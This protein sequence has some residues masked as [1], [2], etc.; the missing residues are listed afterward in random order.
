[1]R[2][3]RH[4]LLLAAFLALRVAHLQADFDALVMWQYE[5]WPM[6]VLAHQLVTGPVIP[7]LDYAD[8][9]SGGQLLTALLAA[10]AF[11]LAGPSDLALKCAGILLA[12][13]AFSV[14]ARLLERVFGPRAA[15]LG[16]A[17][18]VL[19]PPT[20]LRL[21]LT[22]MGNHAAVVPF[23]LLTLLAAHR[24]LRSGTRG[25]A[26][27]FG[28]AA[29]FATYHTLSSALVVL[30]L[31]P[32]IVDL[33]RRRRGPA[34][35]A[36]LACGALPL[37]V[38]NLWHG[39]GLAAFLSARF[40][41]AA[42]T[43]PVARV[44]ELVTRL[45][46]AATTY[47]DLPLAHAGALDRVAFALA[48]LAWSV[49]ALSW[50]R[51]RRAPIDAA[52]HARRRLELALLLHPPLFALAYA[53][54]DFAIGD[55]GATA[56]ISYRY[57]ATNLVLA[58]VLAVAAWRRADASA[59]APARVLARAWAAAML[60]VAAPVLVTAWHGPGEG[61]RRGLALPGHDYTALARALYAHREHYP[62]PA[63]DAVVARLPPALRPA[64]YEGVGTAEAVIAI[65]YARDRHTLAHGLD[66]V[67]LLG[68]HPPTAGPSL[69]RGVGGWLG[70]VYADLPEDGRHGLA[71]LLAQLTPAG[72]G[73][74]VEG[75]VPPFHGGT[76]GQARERDAALDALLASLPDGFADAVARGLGRR[77]ARRWA[78]GL[79]LERARA[80]ELARVRLPGP[81]RL[82]FARGLGMGAGRDA[83]R[84]DVRARARA[85]LG[86]DGALA[87]LAGAGERLALELAGET[88]GPGLAP[89]TEA[90]RAAVVEGFDAAPAPLIPARTTR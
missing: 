33:L 1:V 46:P 66:L 49:L 52:G 85:D 44:V 8:T 78:A 2:S 71:A 67:A 22:A 43:D 50:W 55:K 16:L 5:R 11:A 30:A 25:A 76:G 48:L 17:L 63:I 26:F 61:L 68:R 82:A 64:V 32:A 4:L 47:A 70:R 42:P 60:L 34:L 86:E 45:R 38:V 41:P 53:F 73:R 59:R 37:L 89:L 23:V 80:R 21:S 72:A 79:A 7:V 56:A 84:A 75:M 20:Y 58:I 65:R 6:G 18:L 13:L 54:S 74:I 14:L 87:L 40:A 29:G 10:G 81:R 62:A 28:A 31:G 19:A 15:T 69:L 88:T 3:R 27:G 83:L 77:L 24:A 90:E 12:V 36:G 35:A 9:H 51:S 39:F 57:L